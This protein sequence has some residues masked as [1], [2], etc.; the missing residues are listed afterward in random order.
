MKLI[1]FSLCLLGLIGCSLQ[2]SPP[3]YPWTGP[4]S[5]EERARK[6]PLVIKAYLVQSFA[7]SLSDVSLRS[8]RCFTV[9]KI[10]KGSLY[11]QDHSYICAD[12]F[13]DGAQCLSDVSYGRPYVIFLN[14]VNNRYV[15]R[16][17]DIHS[18]VVGF[19]YNLVVEE[20]L[21]KGLCCSSNNG[22]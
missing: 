9:S 13:G 12:R 6:A 10:Y 1:V 19:D 8:R 22:E 21:R 18:A 14:K 5:I 3:G 2:C 17:D 11:P 20:K 16:Y 15:A 7:K 4:M